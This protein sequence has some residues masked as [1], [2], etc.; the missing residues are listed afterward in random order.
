MNWAR[1]VLLG[2]FERP[3]AAISATAPE[4][5][6]SFE[7]PHAAR[8][9]WVAASAPGSPAFER[10]GIFYRKDDACPILQVQH[11]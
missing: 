2:W 9:R 4:P 6:K 3:A 11:E 1:T 7:L 5:G 8:I 10:A